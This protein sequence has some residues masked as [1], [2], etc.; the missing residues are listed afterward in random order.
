VPEYAVG[1]VGDVAGE[2]TTLSATL[3]TLHVGVQ[4]TILP[5]DAGTLPAAVATMAAGPTRLLSVSS[6]CAQGAKPTVTRA[7]VITKMAWQTVFIT[8]PTQV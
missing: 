4:G 3:F 7:H 5:R 6:T 1:I 2:N 8:S